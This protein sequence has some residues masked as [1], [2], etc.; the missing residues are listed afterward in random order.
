MVQDLLEPGSEHTSPGGQYSFRVLGPCCRLFDREELPW[1]CC[2]LAWRS[3]E[4]SW[5]RIGRRFVADLAA[6]RCPSYAVELLQPGTRPTRTVITLF[7]QRLSGGLQEWWYS[8][9]PSSCEP[10]NVAPPAC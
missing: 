6:R 3:K 8:K 7:A 4:P 5:R 10:G 9:Q 2:R 1:P